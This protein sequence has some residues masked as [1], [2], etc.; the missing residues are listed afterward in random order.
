MLHQPTTNQIHYLGSLQCH[1]YH[2][3]CR[4]VEVRNLNFP[5]SVTR[6]YHIENEN[7]GLR[8]AMFMV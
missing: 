1:V 6:M 4:R 3:F 5:F 8:L 7:Q 2:V